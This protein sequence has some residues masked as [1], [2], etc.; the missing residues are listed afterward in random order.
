MIIDLIKARNELKYG[1]SIFDMELRVVYYGRVSTD[2][3]EQLNSLENQ[4]KFF[5]DYIGNSKHWKLVGR[6]IDEGISGTSIKNR[7]NFLKM[8]EDA[9]D[10]KFDMIITKEVS[11]FARNTVDS[12]KYTDYLLKHGVIVNFLNDNLNTIDET[13]EFRLTIMSSLAQDE[14]RKL[15][16]RVKFGLERAVKDGRVLGGGN[17]TGYIKK[18]GKLIINEDEA[19][20]IRMLFSLYSSGKFGFRA[21]SEK[22]FEAGFKNEKGK[23]YADRVLSRMIENPKYKGYYCG[24]KSYIIDYKT[25]KKVMRPKEE[26]IIY[27]DSNIPAIVS[28]EVWDRANQIYE[29]RRNNHLNMASRR[30]Y[31]SSNTYTGKLTC[32]EHNTNFTRIATGKRKNN[33]VWQCLEY[34]RGGLKRCETPTLFEKHLDSIFKNVIEDFKINHKEVFKSI[35]EDYAKLMNENNLENKFSELS[36]KLEKIKK[37]KKRI[38]DLNLDGALSNEE[39]KEKND[40]YNE[41]ISDINDQILFLQDTKALEENYSKKLKK[42]EKSLTLKLNGENSFKELFDLLVERVYVSKINNNRKHIKFEIIFNYGFESREIVE[43]LRK[44]KD[45]DEKSKSD[46]SLQS[47]SL[48]GYAHRA[49]SKCNAN[50]ANNSSFFNS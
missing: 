3:D 42:L 5:E 24:N 48:L 1:K 19:P 44:Y 25:H 11:R 16:S 33:P 40:K 34:A 10:G 9:C 20:M 35:M 45:L 2:S 21:I 27:K 14:V 4:K 7:T 17:I 13:C 36:K 38:L 18:D 26:W 32:K 30:N 47:G 15:S 12:I 28:E 39:F 49:R 37:Y 43:D 31:Y 6:Y 50:S 23:H 46:I 8:I 29:S 22:L 41:E